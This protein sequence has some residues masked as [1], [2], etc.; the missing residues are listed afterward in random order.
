M[1]D[2][3]G[4]PE[5]S[6][7]A[8][9][10]EEPAVPAVPEELDAATRDVFG[11]VWSAAGGGGRRARDAV[12]GAIE[13]LLDR[14]A[15]TVVDAPLDVTDAR[16][17]H[18]RIEEFQ[19]NLGNTAAVV[20]AP[21]L[22]Q[23]VMRFVRRGKVVPSAALITA[24][25]A[26]L[27]AITLSVFHLRVLASQVVQ[28]LR[29]RGHPVDPAFVR[30]VAVA[31]YLNPGAGTDAVRANRL[32]AVRLATDWGTHA[33]PLIGGRRR[34]AARVQRA[35]QAI[36]ALDLERALARF[37]RERAIDLRERRRED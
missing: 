7:P 11:T 12:V 23:Q 10:A 3:S 25:A 27:T 18:R 34:T 26:T 33:V 6:E 2:Q 9:P 19:S 20:G 32:A 16:A 14:I 30:R 4:P 35:A 37:E 28:R 5:P 31:L 15:T 29:A 36:D 8:E 17:A 1:N 22:V 13:A 21:W 24:A